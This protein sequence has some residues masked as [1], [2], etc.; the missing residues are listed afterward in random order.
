MGIEPKTATACRIAS[1]VLPAI[2]LVHQAGAVRDPRLDAIIDA[3]PKL[4]EETRIDI[5]DQA[6]GRCT[7]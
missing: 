3:W 1:Y 2:P 6:L 4:S 7:N 5:A